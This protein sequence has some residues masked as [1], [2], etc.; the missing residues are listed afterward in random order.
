MRACVCVTG[1]PYL[2][3]GDEAMVCAAVFLDLGRADELTLLLTLINRISVGAEPP[4]QSTALG[5]G[6]SI[7]ICRLH[8]CVGTR[9]HCK[10]QQFSSQPGRWTFCGAVLNSTMRV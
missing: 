10:R 9:G 7:Y 1:D 2:V 8:A 6:D 3:L 4:A 5:G